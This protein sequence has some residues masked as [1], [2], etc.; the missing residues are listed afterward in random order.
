VSESAELHQ[1]FLA[2]AADVGRELCRAAHWDREGH[3][4]NWVGRSVRELATVGG[5][6]VPTAAALGPDLYGGSAGVALFL[7]QLAAVTGDAECRRTACGA[8]ARSIR[9]VKREAAAGA[10]SLSFHAGPLGVAHAAHRVAGLLAEP[11]LGD[12]VDAL[13]KIVV[14]AAG[15][16]HVL[17][18][19]GGSA[20]AIPALLS[21]AR[22]ERWRG[23]AP[24]AVDLGDEL[25]RIA[26]R[27]GGV[28]TWDVERA[29]GPGVGTA[30]LAGLGHGASGLGL[31]LLELYAETGRG[32]FLE[33]GRAAFAYEDT[34][35]D[36]REGN[37]PDLRSFGSAAA[38]GARYMVA[39][40]HGAP[41]IGLARLRARSLDAE[42]RD[43]HTAHSPAPTPA[44]VTAW[45]AW[46]KPCLRAAICWRRKVTA[47][48]RGRPRS[49]S[50]DTP[51]LT[52]G[53]RE[54]RR[55]AL[56]L[57]S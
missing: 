4:C 6:L 41:G 52:A 27:Q 16:P 50:P 20:G 13:L 2:V 46:R 19:L 35:F 42:R 10:P 21:L 5:P 33:G 56:T 44:C 40:C 54:S 49:C 43:A 39:W 14:R 15:E 31:A 9:R 22:E 29:C 8:I 25:C 17:D 34:L 7:A 18:L 28:W 30:M 32:E 57:R 1:G 23:L 26:R 11:G 24:L 55:A 3:L 48:E 53:P 51:P 12:E 47:P 38:P 37:W 45:P 36:P